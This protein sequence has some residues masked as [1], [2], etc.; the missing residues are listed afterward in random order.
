MS[1]YKYRN[2][3][4]QR[5][6]KETIDPKYRIA[7]SSQ[8]PAS[9]DV[10]GNLLVESALPDEFGFTVSS[11]YST[12]F[13]TQS[14]G[15][16]LQKGSAIAGISQKTAFAMNKAFI[17]PEPSEI[18]FE[19]HF[20]A[21]YSARMEVLLPVFRLLEMSLPTL[22]TYESAKERI[23]QVIESIKE[24]LGGTQVDE[25]IFDGIRNTFSRNP[26]EEVQETIDK[27]LALLRVLSSPSTVNIQF[28]NT[29]VLTDTYISSVSVSFSNVLDGEGLPLS[30]V[31]SVTAL[32]RRVP[33]KELIAGEW[34]TPIKNGPNF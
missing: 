16:I 10:F 18:S 23:T 25:S 22:L 5:Y 3:S 34:F 30:A 13:D 7:I 17:N 4:Y 11:N 28:G 31:C 15:E 26:D 14:L 20:D 1:G 9:S 19:M 2:E 32:P 12:P 29:Y 27:G 24:S 21:F 6:L 33:T 8:N